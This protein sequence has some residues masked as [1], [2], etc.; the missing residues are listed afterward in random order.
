MGKSK[1]FVIKTVADVHPWLLSRRQ[2]VKMVQRDTRI[3][4]QQ[5]DELARAA[6][7]EARLRRW[8]KDAQAAAG[9]L[10]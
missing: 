2:L 10:T 5:G 7:R 9:W 1:E 6:Q 4:E 3:I 8:L